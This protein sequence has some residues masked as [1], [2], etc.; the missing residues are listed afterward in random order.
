VDQMAGSTQYRLIL[1]CDAGKRVVVDGLI[2]DNGD[3]NHYDT[4]KQLKIR[5]RANPAKNKNAT[6]E[7][8]GIKIK[9]GTDCQATVKNNVVMN[10]APT[11]GAIATWGGKNSTLTIENNLIINN[12]GEGIYAM[13]AFH[14]RDGQGL[15]S[16]E[17]KNNTILFS[18]KHDA[19]ATYGGNGVKLDSEVIANITGNVLG[20]NDYGAIDNIKKCKKLTVS[21]NLV[22][23]NRLY[24]YREFNTAMKIDAIEDE[25]DILNE[26]SSGNVSKLVKVNVGPRFAAIYAGRKEI[27]RAKVDAAAKVSNSGANQLRGILGLPLQASAVKMDA[28]VWLARLNLDEAMAVAQQ[29]FGEFGAKKP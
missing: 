7:S 23:G 25:S 21:K 12:T 1:G 22:F 20:F 4:D 10:T 24:D 27:S 6:P 11:G 2:I 3:R 15:P 8:G 19:I 13:T 26:K 28:D 17:I 5:R 14:P 16:Y 18:W 9:L 29:S